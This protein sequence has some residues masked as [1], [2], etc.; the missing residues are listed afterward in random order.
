M[1][2]QSFS[3]AVKTIKREVTETADIRPAEKACIRFKARGC[4]LI[5]AVEFKLGRTALQIILI[6]LSAGMGPVVEFR[7]AEHCLRNQRPLRRNFQ[8]RVKPALS[9]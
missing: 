5:Q 2:L 6:S 1:P 3:F 9:I 7:V 4:V 8:F